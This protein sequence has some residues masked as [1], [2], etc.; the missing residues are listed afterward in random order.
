MGKKIH[1]SNLVYDY[2]GKMV[3]INHSDCQSLIGKIGYVTDETKNTIVIISNNQEKKI[4]KS[5]VELNIIKNS[6]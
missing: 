6:Q 5:Q 4:I 2:I 3:K 1:K